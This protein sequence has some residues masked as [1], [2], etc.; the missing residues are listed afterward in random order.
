MVRRLISQSL[1]LSLGLSFCLTVCLSVIVI[2]FEGNASI[3]HEDIGQLRIHDLLLRPN[4]V[5]SEPKSGAFSIGESSFALRWEL[6]DKFS[7]VIRIGPRTLLNPV[8]RF[9]PQVKD[10]VTLVEAFAELDDAFGRVRLG[11]L[12]VEF[13]YEGRKWERALIFPRSLLFSKRAMMLRDVGIAYDISMNNWYTGFV[14]HNGESDSDADGQIWYTARWGYRN[15]D[16]EVGF[17]GQTGS[18]KPVATSASLDTLAGVDPTLDEHWRSGGLFGAITK[19]T[20]EWSVEFYAGEVEQQKRVAKF[21][22]GHM[23]Y[24]L[25]ISKTFSAHIRYDMFDPNTRVDGDLEQAVSLAA[26]LSNPT[27]SSNLILVGT[28]KFEE[29][30]H[31]TPNDELR[32]IWS[33]SPSGTVRF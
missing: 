26:V 13:G 15:D 31:Q 24:S 3:L 19:K 21:Q 32:L 11:R 12:P 25:E 1:F 23:D 30:S 18:T 4:F 28:K 33:L 10:D 16:F 2:G 14:V 5:L 29:G 27:H 22:T 6:E 20:S 8:A 17:M 7:S 9:T